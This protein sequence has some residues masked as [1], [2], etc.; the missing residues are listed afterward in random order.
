[1]LALKRQDSPA[2][3]EHATRA[4]A[5]GAGAAG[6]QYLS[7]SYLTLGDGRRA[8]EHARK[9]AALGPSL[10]TRLALG[11]VLLAAGVFEEASSLLKQLVAEHPDDPD[12]RL[13]LAAVSTQ[14]GDHPTAIVH[15]AAALELRPG[16]TRALEG[17][18]GLFAHVGKWLGAMAALETSK[19]RKPPPEIAIAFDLAHLVLVQRVAGAFPPAGALADADQVVAGAIA[20][21]RTRPVAMQLATARMLFDLGRGADARKL[22]TALEPEVTQPAERAHVRFLEGLFQHQARETTAA[23]A[24]YEQALQLDPTRVDAAIN[25]VSLMLET[26]TA[27]DRIGALLDQVD[28]ALRKQ[29]PELLLNEAV[30]L[31]RTGK[32]EAAARVLD[33]AMIV[34][35]GQGHL[36]ELARRAL[37]ELD[38]GAQPTS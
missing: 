8:I 2:A 16:D 37:D 32:R 22:V 7:T 17:L 1:L 29:S 24:A 4:V 3:I 11:A 10:R 25:A 21:A 30:W 19:Q 18:I 5:L 13:S 34:T 12:A 9:A 36:G 33:R 27:V 23:L 20:T 35:N 28:P 6:H 14:L 26:S 31:V 38:H 15:Y